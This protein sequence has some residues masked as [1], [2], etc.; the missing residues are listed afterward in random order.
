MPS[1]MNTIIIRLILPIFL[2]LLSCQ[3]PTKLEAQPDE[4]TP[5]TCHIS[6]L[7]DYIHNYDT[8]PF[9]MEDNITISGTITS[10]DSSNNHYKEL[11][12]EQL[13]CPLR[14]KIGVY[15]TYKFLPLGRTISIDLKHLR[16]DTTDGI[17]TI[18]PIDTWSLVN[19]H[20]KLQT[21]S[22]THTPTYIDIDNIKPEH[23]GRNV[24]INNIE[25]ID[26]STPMAGEKSI[27]Q[28]RQNGSTSK[29]LKVYTSAYANFADSLTPNGRCTSISGILKKHKNNFQL[30]LNDYNDIHH[31]QQQ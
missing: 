23:L 15:D 22:D 31:Q 5:I 27:V 29:K 8:L 16:L 3:N 9:Y 24:I 26:Q 4:F 13:Q 28:I 20:I 10:S 6:Q 14:L 30:V 21:F 2:I 17:L 12:I 18:G 7:W 1:E 11:Y 19:K 25:F